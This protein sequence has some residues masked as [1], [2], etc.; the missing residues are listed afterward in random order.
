MRTIIGP[1]LKL[2]LSLERITGDLMRKK[3]GLTISQF[4]ILMALKFNPDASQKTI[5]EFW[6][7]TEPSVSRQIEL[8]ESKKIIVKN[9]KKTDRRGHSFILSA[10]GKKILDKALALLD[11]DMEKL[12]KTVSQKERLETIRL[13]T[14]L[15]NIINDRWK[16]L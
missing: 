10:K 8:L 1:I 16:N 5:A 15:H 4:R 7:V 14:S 13:L 12:F 6:G 2:F 3:L 9:K 11:D